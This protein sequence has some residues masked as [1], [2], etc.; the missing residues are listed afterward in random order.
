MVKI[1]FTYNLSINRFV[2]LVTIIL[3]GFAINDTIMATA[4]EKLANQINSTNSQ[5]KDNCNLVASEWD[6]D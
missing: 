2:I 3:F 6:K 5:T 4:Q 1:Q